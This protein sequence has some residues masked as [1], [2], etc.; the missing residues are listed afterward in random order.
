MIL[1][2]HK[3][4]RFSTVLRKWEGQ[5]VV[6]IA[7]GAS[8]TPEQVE[9][10]RQ[11]HYDR[12]LTDHL[13]YGGPNGTVRT[14]VVNDAYLLAPWADVLYAADSRWWDWHAKGIA[15]PKLNLTA[16]QVRERF[17]AFQG[18]RCS[19]QYSGSNIKDDRVHL[20]KNMTFPLPDHSLG[21]SLDPERLVTGRNSGFQAI[22]LI[23]LAGAKRILLLGIDGRLNEKDESHFHGGHPSPTPWSLFFEQMRK[24]FAAAETPLKEAG[25][26][27]LNCSPGTAI[28]HFRKI[29][30]ERALSVGVMV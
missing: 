18:E 9:F 16:D 5:T 26:E 1:Q 7:G 15:K 21:L 2:R 11:H 27:V 19:I 30:L 10:V 13:E 28:D 6:L 23:V 20:L 8:V 29:S 25:V 3:A 12:P 17:E 24:T 14:V 22:N 4:D